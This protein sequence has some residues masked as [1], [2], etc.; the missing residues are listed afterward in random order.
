MI[1]DT[2]G[3][4]YEPIIND[5]GNISRI[6]ITKDKIEKGIETNTDYFEANA[7]EVK[8]VKEITV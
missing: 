2:N 7:D 3:K 6:T 8:I 5:Y 1:S 4:I